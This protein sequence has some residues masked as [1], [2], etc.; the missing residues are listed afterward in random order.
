MRKVSVH[1]LYFVCFQQNIEMKILNGECWGSN[2]LTCSSQ[3]A[4]LPLPPAPKH[5]KEYKFCIFWCRGHFSEMQQWGI[6][7]QVSL[8]LL[9]WNLYRVKQPTNIVC[10]GQWF[11]LK[12]NTTILFC[13]VWPFLQV[14]FIFMGDVM[15][16]FVRIGLKTG[17]YLQVICFDPH[18]FAMFWSAFWIGHETQ[19]YK[20]LGPKRQEMWWM[21]EWFTKM[22]CIY[23]N[24]N[25]IMV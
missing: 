11:Q 15:I 4:F 6:G 5:C 16:C 18:F 19:S 3:S 14:V 22:N 24:N 1:R 8:Y 9:L 23:S 25:K 21:I 2:T 17:L 12:H 13:F 20:S 10:F 7:V